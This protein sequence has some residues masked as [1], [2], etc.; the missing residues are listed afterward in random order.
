MTKLIQEIKFSLFYKKGWGVKNTIPY[1]Q[2]TFANLITTYHKPHLM[3][4]YA[5]ILESDSQQQKEIKNTL[6]P[7]ITPHGTFNER[8]D[9][10]IT[11]HNEHLI[12]LD[13]DG[14]ERWDAVK[15]QEHLSKQKGCA[16]CV[17]SPRLN[18][19]KAFIL[20]RNPIDPHQ[21]YKHLDQNKDHIIQA[22]ELNGYEL[23]VAQFILSQSMFLG[24][25]P[26]MFFNEDCDCA[27]WDLNPYIEPIPKIKAAASPILK[28][29]ILYDYYQS[30]I[31]KYL[32]NQC[33]RLVETL[34]KK[35]HP[36]RHNAI[37]YCYRLASWS[38]YA[39]HYFMEII[40]AK[41][42]R[43]VVKMYGDEQTAIDN[44]A[45]NSFEDIWST[46]D[47]NKNDIIDN[48]IDEYKCSINLKSLEQ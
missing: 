10:S 14:L 26:H 45:L 21:R 33:D 17:L 44:N 7:Y 35:V 34:S 46:N 29:H 28:D 25:S 22:L 36:Y 40:K 18:G 2:I 13:I 37:G 42:K 47:K 6:L 39:D 5:K 1:K 43:A 32:D 27:D 30:R 3:D 31:E 23:D 20:L 38:H 16:M 48:I 4:Q 19:V 12:C 11:H 41:L 24:H 9:K 15:V 8:N